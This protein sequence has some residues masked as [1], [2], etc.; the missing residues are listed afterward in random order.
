MAIAKQVIEISVNDSQQKTT[1]AAPVDGPEPGL[2]ETPSH[3]KLRQLFAHAHNGALVLAYGGAGVGK[4]TAA[5]RY[6]DEHREYG[7]AAYLINLLGVKTPTQ[8]LHTIAE[9]IRAPAS[10]GAYRNVSLMR[11]LGEY[12]NS[13]EM[14]ILDESQSLRP[15]ALDI[16]RFFLDSSGVGLALLGNEL[17]FSAIA[18]KN[19]R[20]MFAQLHSRVGMRLHIPHPTEAD[21]DAVLAA[22][23][24][25]DGPGKDYGRQIALG[26]GGL[27]QLAQVLRQT[28]IAAAATKRAMDHQLMYAAASALGLAD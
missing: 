18:G 5:T 2:V 24:I 11:A 4:T 16:L 28:R 7:K 6:A 1:V 25:V 12:L 26:P 9:G 22:W 14:L 19:R 3:K 23:G 27:R 13:S 8:M 21:A 15:D 10:M 17:V 20:A